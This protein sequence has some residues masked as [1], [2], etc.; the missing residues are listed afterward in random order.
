MPRTLIANG[1]D[2]ARLARLADGLVVA[3]A[4]S[5]PWS[6]SATAILAVL[7]LVALIPTIDWSDVRRQLATLPGG[8]PVLLVAFGLVGVLWAD[9]TLL[10][11]W[12][13]LDSFVKLLAIP[14]LFVQFRRSDRGDWVFA[15]YLFSCIALVLAS[16]IVMAIPPLA[17]HLMHSDNVLLKNQATQSGEFVTCIFGL[18]YLAI[19]VCERRS[20]GFLLGILA[21][22]LSMLANIF[23][24]ATG[25]TALVV[26]LVLLMLL[27]IKKLSARGMAI[28]F[29]GAIVASIVGWYTS[30]YLR[31]R[32]E[33]VWTDLQK[34]EATNERNSSGE[35]VEF[36]KKSI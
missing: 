32:T 14:L 12:K 31:E 25:R 24:V 30:P 13:G 20:W 8:L 5:L 1:F 36:W 19:D 17:V 16:T 7:W 29:A 26:I 10:E 2:Q 11:R 18:L 6:T 27:A 4:V 21:V 23:F 35:R 3:L 22:V 9:V 33:T 15:G 28:V 34:Y